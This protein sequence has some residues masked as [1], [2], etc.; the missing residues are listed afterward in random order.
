MKLVLV[1]TGFLKGQA[2]IAI[3][4]IG[5]KYLHAIIEKE[6]AW[7]VMQSRMYHL[8]KHDEKTPHI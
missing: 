1:L 7:L 8:A 6:R 2:V 4:K 5:G 3:T